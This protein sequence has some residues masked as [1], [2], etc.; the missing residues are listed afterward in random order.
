MLIAPSTYYDHINRQP[1]SHDVIEPLSQTRVI[2]QNPSEIT[3]IVRPK[4]WANV[5]APSRD[6][7]T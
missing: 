5:Q 6:Y 3:P 1:V 7:V 4:F 2:F